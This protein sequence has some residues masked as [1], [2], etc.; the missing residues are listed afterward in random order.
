MD[1]L[2][3]DLRKNPDI[4][5]LVT[6]MQPGDPVTLHTTL[7]H[8]D[9]QTLQLTVESAEEGEPKEADEGASD[10]VP[11]EPAASVSPPATPGMGAAMDM[12]A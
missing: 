3:I 6:D 12:G 2:T 9:E 10:E 8:K 11:A 7:K 1:T 4:A 5:G